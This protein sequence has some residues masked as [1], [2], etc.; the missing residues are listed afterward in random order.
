[1]SNC[2]QDIKRDLVSGC[3]KVG[4]T[5]M[6]AT[7]HT[8]KVD[9]V[10]QP[11]GDP[12]TNDKASYFNVNGAYYPAGA[13]ANFTPGAVCRD[14]A[15]NTVKVRCDVQ[16]DGT[17]VRYAEHTT[18]TGNDN[19]LASSVINTAL[20]YPYTLYQITGT[21]SDCADDTNPQGDACCEVTHKKLQEMIDLMKTDLESPIPMCAV[22]TEPDGSKTYRHVKAIYQRDNNTLTMVGLCDYMGNPT[23]LGADEV[24]GGCNETVTD[25][26]RTT[27]LCGAYGNGSHV[28]DQNIVYS[29][30]AQTLS[31]EDKNGVTVSA[32]GTNAGSETF[33]AFQAS[34]DSSGGLKLRYRVENGGTEL[35]H[36]GDDEIEIIFSEPVTNTFTFNE[37]K[38][39]YRVRAFKGTDPIELNFSQSSASASLLDANYD[40]AT[41]N[42]TT[43]SDADTQQYDDYHGFV[44]S[45][46]YDKIL[47]EP[48]QTDWTNLWI[49]D[50]TNPRRAPG[51]SPATSPLEYTEDSVVHEIL[52]LITGAVTYEKQDGTPYSGDLQ[53]LAPC[54]GGCNCEDQ[55][56]DVVEAIEKLGGAAGD[57]RCYQDDKGD[58]YRM[59]T[60]TGVSDGSITF[61]I[62]EVIEVIKDVSSSALSPDDSVDLLATPMTQIPCLPYEPVQLDVCKAQSASEVL[63]TDGTDELKASVPDKTD[64]MT[65]INNT[66]ES[67]VKVHLDPTGSF[68]VPVGAVATYTVSQE[69]ASANEL[70][71]LKITKED[72]TALA[73]GEQLL[74][75]YRIKPNV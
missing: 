40:Q 32:T 33:N 51:M 15:K 22:T 37:V 45:A 39:N 50:A 23:A 21:P 52:N 31:A 43:S 64:Q 56:K 58:Q 13:V 61:K 55:L 71:V 49:N 7:Y 14:L 28:F 74:I 11:L 30:V 59:N 2:E 24:L 75:N 1:M 27:E 34:T 8:V 29:T 9:G 69:Q 44:A 67:V 4:S 16:D 41:G 20:D 5:Y 3:L 47:I 36:T 73:A 18:W 25:T 12:A 63:E 10:V 68:L 26:T 48:A 19:A 72:D 65:L 53:Y 35:A 57:T 38:H 62:A 54:A 17:V 6:T 60:Y 46:P 66:E 70:K 42:V